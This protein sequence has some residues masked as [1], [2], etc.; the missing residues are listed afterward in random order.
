MEAG[1]QEGNKALRQQGKNKGNEEERLSVNLCVP[2][3][4]WFNKKVQ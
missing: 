1:R 2:L 3:P 4:L